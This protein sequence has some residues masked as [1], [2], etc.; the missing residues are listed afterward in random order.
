MKSSTGMSRPLRASRHHLS[1][2]GEA[3]IVSSFFA[4]VPRAVL[5]PLGTT[6]V[7]FEVGAG[8]DA[9]GAEEEDAKEAGFGEATAG[10]AAAPEA[11]PDDDELAKREAIEAATE[12][13]VIVFALALA[14]SPGARTAAELT[15]GEGDT[16]VAGFAPTVVQAPPA[17]AAAAEGTTNLD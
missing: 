12:V 7:M 6:F 9:T 4:E 1:S 15:D 2:S 3:G 16:V 11:G 14:A 5:R 10:E 17:L 13:G 8:E